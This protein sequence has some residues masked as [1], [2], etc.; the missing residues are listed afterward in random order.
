M[1]VKIINKK[2]GVAKDLK[3]TKSGPVWIEKKIKPVS[4]TKAKAPEI[5]LSEPGRLRVG[6]VL[7]LLS[8]SHS[9]F[10][11]GLKSGRYPPADGRDG[12]FPY[13]KTST[14]KKFL[15]L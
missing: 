4:H 10:Y 7:S 13:W 5:S 8:I 6:H 1:S 11:A 9:T 2:T 14:I 12:N 3:L 15:D